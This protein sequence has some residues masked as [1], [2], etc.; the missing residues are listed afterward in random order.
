MGIKNLGVFYSLNGDFSFK[1]EEEFQY[2]LL[3]FSPNEHD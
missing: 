1:P 3:D 2:S